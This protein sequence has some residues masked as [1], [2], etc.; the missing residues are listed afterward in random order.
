MAKNRSSKAEAA[1]EDEAKKNDLDFPIVGI[2]A[3]A[4]GLQA[5]EDFFNG[6]PADTDPNMAFILVQHLDPNHKSMLAEL[7]Q[8]CTHMQVFEVEDGME[9]EANCIY[10]IVPD[11]DMAISKGRLQLLTPSAARSKRLPIDFFFR[12]LADH[13]HEQ[14]IGIVL[15]GTGSDGTQ[16]IRAIKAEAGMVIAQK[17]DTAGFDGMPSSAIAT[18]L[19]DFVL[20]PAEMPDQLIA[21]IMHSKSTF[22]S[23]KSASL[24]K[25]ENALNK[26]FTLLRSQT[27]NDFSQ[28]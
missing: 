17:P 2:G 3:S 18:G 16:G 25:G 8:R 9:I 4:G 7:I 12:S 1:K 23:V 26:I 14:A 10:T 15:S 19:V 11:R 27:G 21:Y 6:M 5:F 24:F 28:Y 20:P 13:Q 22:D